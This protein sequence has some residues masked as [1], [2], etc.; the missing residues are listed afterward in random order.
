MN[1]YQRIVVIVTAVN[2]AL[3]CLFPPFL[4]NPL[5]K[6]VLPGFDGFYP[7]EPDSGR[8]GLIRP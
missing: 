7:L 2:I 8:P 6:G 3:M 5:R 1:K 4:D